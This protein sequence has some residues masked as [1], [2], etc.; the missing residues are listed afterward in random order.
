VFRL[1]VYALFPQVTV[2]FLLS[3]AFA[4]LSS[5]C[6]Q[7]QLLWVFDQ[8]TVVRSGLKTAC[9]LASAPFICLGCQCAGLKL[10]FLLSAISLFLLPCLCRFSLLSAYCSLQFAVIARRV[11]VVFSRFL[12]H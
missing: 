1:S 7:G 5:C 12:L 4:F 8:L 3:C 10:V 11:T 9:L 6:M 2:F